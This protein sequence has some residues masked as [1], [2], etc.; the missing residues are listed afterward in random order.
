MDSH[1]G[2]HKACKKGR[3]ANEN[4]HIPASNQY[5]IYYF[6]RSQSQTRLFK[7]YKCEHKD[8]ETGEACGFSIFSMSKYFDHLRTHTG[9]KPYECDQCDMK[10][11][12]KGN[13][14][15]HKEMIH[16][17]LAKFS[18]GHCNKVFTKKF[19][20]QVH[21]KNLERKLKSK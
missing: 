12:Q 11:S 20:L 21:L 16:W 2:K 9:E 1:E 10:F 8:Q 5:S 19:N 18:C 4:I 13:L 3:W 14:D 7:L 17:G 6:L 15:K